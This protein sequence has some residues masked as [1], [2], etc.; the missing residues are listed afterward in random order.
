MGVEIIRAAF[1]EQIGII[2][3]GN[4]HCYCIRGIGNVFL[5]WEVCKFIRDARVSI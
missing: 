1:C 4:G 2:W 3:A 5:G